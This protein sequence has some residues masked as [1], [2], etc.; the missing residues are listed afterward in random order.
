[1]SDK[2]TQQASVLP[3]FKD[4]HGEPVTL[5]TKINQLTDEAQQVLLGQQATPQLPEFKDR[6]GR[7]LQI[8]TDISQLSDTSKQKLRL[9]L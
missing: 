5:D 6:F 2:L 3:E 7:S 1:M 8:D 9:D 4:R